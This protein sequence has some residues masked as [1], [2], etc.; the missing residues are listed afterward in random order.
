[1]AYTTSLVFSS[2]ADDFPLESSGSNFSSQMSKAINWIR[3]GSAGSVDIQ[4]VSIQNAAGASSATITLASALAG[5]VVVI[6]G[7]NF[8]AQSGGT[9]PPNGWDM[10]GTDTVDAASLALAINSS[11]STGILGVVKATSALG[12]VTVTGP[13]GIGVSFGGILASGTV[14]AAAV[15]SGDTVTINGTVLTSEQENARGTVT[16]ASSTAG[17]TVTVNGTPFTAVSG[18][19]V[20]PQFDISGNDTADAASLAAAINANG[21]L[22]ST[23][24]ATSAAAVVTLRAVASGTGGNAYTLASSN[25]TR[26]AVSGTL[27]TGGLATS[28]NKWDYGDTA[29]QSAAEIVRAFNASSTTSMTSAATVR[30]TLGVVTVTAK[31]PGAAGNAVTLASSNNTRL[32]V[33]GARL[34][35]GSDGNTKATGTVTLSSSSGSVSAIINGVT[36]SA[37][38]VTDDTATASLLSAAINNNTN[39]LVRGQVTA[40]SALGVVTITAV[41]SGTAG[42]LITLAASGTGA[43][44]S[45]TR[46]TSGATNTTV[47]VSSPTLTGGTVVTFSN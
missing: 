20:G 32:A 35:G 6:N 13:A 38:F 4:S 43:T 17:D 42:N 5:S 21:Q 28:N 33:S 14:T 1:M 9:L 3:G 7:V 25:N 31:A 45:G 26:L 12:V 40:T 39:A 10:S 8:I 47:V 2:G 34:T 15:Q 41:T 11:T 27:L 24:T 19:P 18:T 30:N 16:L 23:I 37:T 29:T 22:S 46:L 44:A 36:S